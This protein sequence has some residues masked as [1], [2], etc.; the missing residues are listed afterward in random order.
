MQADSTQGRDDSLLRSVLALYR[1]LWRFGR[2]RRGSM[3]AAAL[4]LIGAELMRLLLPWLAGSA[5]NVLQVQGVAGLGAAARYLV[6]LLGVVAFAWLCHGIGRL[7]ERNVALHA[8]A[9]F[10]LDLMARLL[11]A[12]LWW[13]RQE[14][15]TEVAQRSQQGTQAL[16]DFAE[17]QY[18]YLQSAVQI[19]GPLVALWWISPSV[20]VAAVIGM[21]VLAISSLSFDRVLLRLNDFMNAADRHNAATWSDLLGNF[22]TLHALRLCEGALSLIR[23]RLEAIFRPL[24]RVVLINELKWAVIDVLGTLLWCSLVTL[25]VVQAAAQEVPQAIALGSVFMVYEYARRMEG[26]MSALA[27]DFSMLAGQLSGFRAVTPLLNAPRSAAIETPLQASAW[28]RLQLADVSFHY[29]QQSRGLQQVD[30][31]LQ[32][33]RRYALIGASGGGKSTLLLLLAGLETPD[34]GLMRLDDAAIDSVALRREACLIPTV[35]ALFEG[36]IKDNLAPGMAAPGVSEQSQADLV[37]MRK[38]LR[39]VDL[40]AHIDRLPE[41][42]NSVVS[43]G[44]SRWSAGQQQ[45]L[46]LARGLLAA[47]DASLVLLDEPT[48]HLDEPSAHTVLARLLDQLA[49]KCVVAAVHDLDL[50]EHFDEVIF[51]DAGRVVDVGPIEPLQRKHAALR[52]LLREQAAQPLAVPL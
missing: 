10:A 1:A 34:E 52:R 26:S 45:R 48:A 20:G 9:A 44:S 15:P 24:R 49:G 7:L 22:L 8:R 46:A 27:A 30:L 21:S 51:V 12:P 11:R 4:L 18:I 28:Q 14:H 43:A 16:N 25:Y 5:M 47:R 2:E 6:L 32:R 37:T 42:L 19:A 13:H 35:A 17:S 39:V 3:L 31:Q 36:S 23:Q 33:D 29:P 38:A 40:I 50:L 41:R